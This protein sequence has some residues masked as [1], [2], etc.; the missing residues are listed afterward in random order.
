MLEGAG[1]IE[2]PAKEVKTA[3]RQIA[4]TWVLQLR[5]S[6]VAGELR[7]LVDIVGVGVMLFVHDTL[8]RAKFKAKDADEEEA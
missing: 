6:K 8:V 2:K 3:K 4:E 1:K 5:T 7:V